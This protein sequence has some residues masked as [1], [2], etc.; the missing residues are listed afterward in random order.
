MNLPA[1]LEKRCPEMNVEKLQSL[2]HAAERDFGEKTAAR[3]ALVDADVEIL[4]V[5]DRQTAQNRVAVKPAF[6]APVFAE[7]KIHLQFFGD[8]FGLMLALVSVS[9][10]Q[11]FLQSDDISIDFPQNFRNSF[12]REPPVNADA[13]VDVVGRDANS[14][15]LVL[16]LRFWVLDFTET[17][18]PK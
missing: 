11:N 9:M 10:T 6:N 5:P 18:D 17:I 3:L 14:I 2:M 7:E 8:K 15:H 1:A 4:R 12:R 16:G 13:F